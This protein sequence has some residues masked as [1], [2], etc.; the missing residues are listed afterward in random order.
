[1]KKI[2][3]SFFTVIL[4]ACS[5]LAQTPEEILAKMNQECA[6]FDTEGVSMVMD[7]KL[8]ILGTYSTQ[9]YILGDKSKA[10]LDVKGDVSIIWSD[11][12][13]DWD[14]DVSKNELTIKPANPS[15]ENEDA[16][17]NVNALKNVTE[18]Y[19]VKLKKETDEAW[20]FVCTKSKDN[21]NKDDPKKMDLV[22]SKATF[23]P[24]SHSV[25]EKGVTVTLR[26][27]AIGV[28]EEQVTFDPAK[29]ANAKIIDK[30]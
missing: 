3:I 6:R 24:V 25:K 12:I 5:L 18:G 4:A 8:P 22:V 26:N 27:F 13:T 2:L 1:M 17:D 11:N 16:G 9:M 7:M 23:L 10:V 19:D 30:R 29:Y 20:Y 28:T 14:Y 21:T 15:D